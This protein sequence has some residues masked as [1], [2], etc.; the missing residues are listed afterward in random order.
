MTVECTHAIAV[1]H[2]KQR[3]IHFPS[4]YPYTVQTSRSRIIF[5][6][7]YDMCDTSNTSKHR[8]DRDKISARPAT[9][10]TGA[11]CP[12]NNSKDGYQPEPA[13]VPRINLHGTFTPRGPGAL[14]TLKKSPWIIKNRTTNIYKISVHD[15]PPNF[16][17]QPSR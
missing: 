17:Y 4:Q 3:H 7:I 5:V 13:R 14:G 8:W 9:N 2:R 16:L 15:I 11:L 10:K 6:T 1:I 12:H